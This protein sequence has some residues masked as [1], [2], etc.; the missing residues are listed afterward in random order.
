MFSMGNTRPIE[1]QRWQKWRN[2]DRLFEENYLISTK[3]EHKTNV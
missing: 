3:V 1:G 2:I